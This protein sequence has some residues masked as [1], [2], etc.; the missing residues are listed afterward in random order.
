MTTTYIQVTDVQGLLNATL[1]TGASQ[2]TVYGLQISQTSFQANVAYA[3][4]YINGLLGTDLASTDPR[5]AIAQ[6]AAQDLACLRILA[7]VS[8]G[9][10]VGAFDYFLGDMRVIR[11]G[12]YAAALQRSIEGFKDD[13]ARQL[14]NLTPAAVA[15]DVRAKGD[16]PTYRG[17]LASP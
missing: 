16:V 8:G 1:D 7:I 15:F 6:L 13:L 5:Y 14:V 10:L 2:Y 11:H 12:P 17:G 9:S 4:T 3:N